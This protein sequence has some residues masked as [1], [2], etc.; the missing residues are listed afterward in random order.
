MGA[1]ASIFLLVLEERHNLHQFGLGF[2]DAGH[3]GE[4]DPGVALDEHLGPGLADAHQPAHALFFRQSAKQ[5]VPE[6][7]DQDKGKPAQQAGEEGVFVDPGEP[8]A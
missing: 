7:H 3:V 5:E 2:I 1:Q 4:G 8:D 6:H